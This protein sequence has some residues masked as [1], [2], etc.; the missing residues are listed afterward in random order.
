MSFVRRYKQRLPIATQLIPMPNSDATDGTKSRK[1]E[2][3]KLTVAS[4][5]HPLVSG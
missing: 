5:Q 3:S 1:D 2:I 4:V